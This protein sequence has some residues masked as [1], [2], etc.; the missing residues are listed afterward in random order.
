M[1][2]LEHLRAARDQVAA[3]L[4]E[5]TLRPKPNYAIEGQQVAWQSLF[6]SYVSQ[7]GQLDALLSAAEPFEFAT[8]AETTP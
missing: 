7:L 4:A 3:N 2:Y 1:T 5:I 6:D 8:R